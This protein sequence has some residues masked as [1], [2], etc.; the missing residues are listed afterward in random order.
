MPNSSKVIAA[1]NSTVP[2]VYSYI[3][4]NI[5]IIHSI[6]SPMRFPYKSMQTV[7]AIIRKILPEPIWRQKP[8]ECI[9]KMPCLG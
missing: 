7:L 4:S 9:G 1:T 6:Y 5:I 3:Y 2:F 8:R